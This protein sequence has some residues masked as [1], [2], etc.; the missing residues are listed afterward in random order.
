MYVTEEESF[1]KCRKRLIKNPYCQNFYATELLRHS[2][3]QPYLVHCHKLSLVFLPV[4][5]ES[6]GDTPNGNDTKGQKV[7]PPRKFC[8][9][10]ERN[11]STNNVSNYALPA[12]GLQSD[13]T[14]VSMSRA[15]HENLRPAPTD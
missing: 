7:T 13:S 5:S 4:K 12:S 15:Q 3:L 14:L 2:H 10:D 8:I 9:V 11:P 6:F 1:V